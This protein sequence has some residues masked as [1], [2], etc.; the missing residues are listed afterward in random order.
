MIKYI[1]NRFSAGQKSLQQFEAVALRN[2]YDGER[3]RICL[4]YLRQ[5][6][7][8]LTAVMPPAVRELWAAETETRGRRKPNLP[9]P[10]RQPEIMKTWCLVSNPRLNLQAMSRRLSPINP[11]N[12]LP[13]KDRKLMT[14]LSRQTKT[15]IKR[16]FRKALTGG[17]LTIKSLGRNLA[18]LTSLLVC[19]PK[20]T[21]NP[22][23][24]SLRSLS[25]MTQDFLRKKHLR[26]AFRLSSSFRLEI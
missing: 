18:R 16:T 22:M 24:T 2:S 19:L 20:D 5:T 8:C 14:N 11:Q 12:H 4:N 1:Y 3:S 21:A 6:L 9:K 13:K 10:V 17:M 23:L 15:F 25:R 26:K 7:L